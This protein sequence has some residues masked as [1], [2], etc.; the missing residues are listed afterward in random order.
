M[1][2]NENER[3][4]IAQHNEVPPVVLHVTFGFGKSSSRAKKKPQEK[5]QKKRNEN[6]S[7][8]RSRCRTTERR[9]GGSALVAMALLAATRLHTVQSV[10]FPITSGHRHRY[11]ECL[12]CSLLSSR[13]LHE[14]DREHLTTSIVYWYHKSI[15]IRSTC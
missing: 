15:S 11:A 13:V 10:S 5:H 4:P 8:E 2:S 1:R 9:G 3:E 7:G 6:L 12:Y 14:C